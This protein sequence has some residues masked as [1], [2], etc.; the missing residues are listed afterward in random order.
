MMGDSIP[1]DECFEGYIE[2]YY[3]DEYTKYSF[4]SYFY[5]AKG[6]TVEGINYDDGAVL[7]YYQPDDSDSGLIEGEN[8]YIEAINSAK[9]YIEH[10][11]MTS[12]SPAWSC[13]T[14][15]Y[16]AGFKVGESISFTLPAPKSGEYMLLASFANAKDYGTIQTLVNGDEVGSPIDTYGTIVTADYLTEIGTVKLTKGY[17]NTLAFE[18]T[19]KNASS[20]NYYFGIDFVLLVPVSEYTSLSE[21]DLSAYTD[22]VRLNTKSDVSTTDSYTF[23]GETYLMENVFVDGGTAEAQSM[24]G[25]GTSWSGGG[26]LWWHL[27]TTTGDKM[28]VFIFVEEAGIYSLSGGFTTAKDYGIIEVYVNGV[29]VG[30]AFDGYNASVAHR[31]A[32]LGEVT[33]NAGANTIEIKVIGKNASA[34]N[35]YVGIDYLR[36]VQK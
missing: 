11:P 15:M 25:F 12:Y 22:V 8:L 18:I 34:T 24:S 20:T 17:T 36:I 5:R 33:L 30:D 7:D 19:G 21:L 23:E 2:K 26:Q 27:G 16:C 9:G 13:D 32:G 14:Q 35:Y 28:N 10:Q 3:T 29:K 1:F 4:T 6:S 31:S